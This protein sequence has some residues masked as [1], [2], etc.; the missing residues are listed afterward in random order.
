MNLIKNLH[1][2]IF[3]SPFFAG[4][5]RLIMQFPALVFGMSSFFIVSIPKI[6]SVICF[7][8]SLPLIANKVWNLVRSRLNYQWSKVLHNPSPPFFHYYNKN[9]LI[10]SDVPLFSRFEL[11]L[12]RI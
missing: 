9:Y 10:L 2:D 5:T 3:V 11:V 12:D 4:G 6:V 7:P 8:S 1:C